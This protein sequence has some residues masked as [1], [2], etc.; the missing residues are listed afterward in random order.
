METLILDTGPLVAYLSAGEQAHTWVAK[1][2]RGIKPPVLTCD[3]VLTEAYYLLSKD[4]TATER[5][6]DLIVRGVIVSVFDS[7]GQVERLVRL[8]QRYADIPMPFADACV[9]CMTEELPTSRVFT[10]D[11]DFHVYRR[12]GRQPIPVLMPNAS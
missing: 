8:M 10:L 9:V 3:A 6:H 11:S 4:N 1:V 7:S 2:F 5:L 12:H